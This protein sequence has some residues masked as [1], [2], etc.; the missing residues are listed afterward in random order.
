MVSMRAIVSDISN[1]KTTLYKYFLLGC[2]ASMLGACSAKNLDKELLKT[3]DQALQADAH[4][5]TRDW[6]RVVRHD[7]SGAVTSDKIETIKSPRELV[8]I[9]PN[10]FFALVS[11]Q[12]TNETT[13]SGSPLIT[14]YTD[15]TIDMSPTLLNMQVNEGINKINYQFLYCEHYNADLSCASA[16]VVHEQ[17]SIYINVVYQQN[18]LDGVNMV[19]PTTEECAS[20]KS[21]VFANP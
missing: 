5:L 8:S 1:V 11:S 7:C 3:P 6:K 21:R 17:G 12:F 4:V 18:F 10:T 2:L 13:G 15:F 19:Y 16:P 14:N 20:Q 9:K